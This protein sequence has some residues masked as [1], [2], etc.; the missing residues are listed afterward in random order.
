MLIKTTFFTGLDQVELPK[1]AGRGERFMNN[2]F[3]T[4]DRRKIAE[5]VTAHEP[6]IGAVE[7]D[8]LRDTA[9]ALIYRVGEA[10]IDRTDLDPSLRALLIDD[11]RAVQALLFGMWLEKD[12]A[13]FLDRGW[14]AGRIGSNAIV[15]NNSWEVRLS[16]S[17]GSYQPVHFDMEELRRA[18][19][20]TKARG[21][22]I[23]GVDRP[24]MLASGTHRYQRLTYFVG[25]ARAATDIA[26]K[27]IQYCSALEALVSTSHTELGHQVSERVACLLS[28]PGPD[29]IGIFRIVKEAY[30]YRSRAVHGASFKGSA[31]ER[32][33]HCSQ[34]LDG[35]CRA[36]AVLCLNT[37]NGL[38]AELARKDDAINRFFLEKVL[39][40]PSAIEPG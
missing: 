28:P 6:Q 22:Y 35:I 38:V 25:A 30:G 24:T 10:E 12:N 27:T 19:N 37:E 11:L 21:E 20:V 13:A 18:R 23:G 36:L 26:I 16:K 1:L 39:S 17:D 34:K 8:W 14:L 3:L 31:Y 9:P 15:S 40:T 33:K 32:L 5:L 4:N 2:Y 29:R 7:A